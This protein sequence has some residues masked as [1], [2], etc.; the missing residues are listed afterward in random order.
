MLRAFSAK[1]SLFT[2]RRSHR[3]FAAGDFDHCER[4]VGGEFFEELAGLAFAAFFDFTALI[5]SDGFKFKG[6][7]VDRIGTSFHGRL[8]LPPP[9]AR[10]PEN[11]ID[12]LTN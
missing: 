4:D 9:Q 1:S 8:R 7:E 2:L 3:E 12:A 6:G 5:E 11:E 10:I